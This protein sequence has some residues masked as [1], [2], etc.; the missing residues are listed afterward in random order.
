MSDRLYVLHSNLCFG[1]LQAEFTVCVQG[2][3]AIRSHGWQRCSPHCENKKTNVSK[4][5]QIHTDASTVKRHFQQSPKDSI[6]YHDLELCHTTMYV[7]FVTQFTQ[8]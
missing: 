7:V 3:Q 1:S 2:L 6:M 4:N 8:P 5:K